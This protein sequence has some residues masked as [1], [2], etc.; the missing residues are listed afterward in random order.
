MSAIS[1]AGGRPAPGPHPHGPASA[2]PLPAGIRDATPP[3]VL[4]TSAGLAW[5]GAVATAVLFVWLGRVVDDGPPAPAGWLAPVLLALTAA[6][7]AGVGA[8]F[9]QW[10]ASAAEQRLRRATVSR[11]FDLGVAGT[12]G[13]S[14][15]LLSLATDAVE[16]IAHYRAAFLG[17]IVGSLTTPLLVLGVMALLVDAVTAGWLV[18]TILLVPLLI[19][20]FQRAVRPIGASYRRT[21]A[22]LTAGFLEAIQALDTLV[23]ARAANRIG[24]DLEA[25]GEEHRRGLMRMLA[26]NQL[27]IFVVDAA[28][29]LT[30]VV[31]ATAIAVVRAA[32]GSISAG[33]A[34]AIVLL[35]VLVTG[36][37]DVIGQFFYIGI[38][39]RAAQRQ[40]AD[41]LGEEPAPRPDATGAGAP[42]PASPPVPAGG[43]ALE[44]VTA[45][46]P[47]GRPV[48]QDLSLSIV[49]GERVA[50]VGPSG[51]GKSTV[52]A[53]IQAHLAPTAG[54]VVVD[55]LD[56]AGDAEAVRSRLTVV[57]QRPF[58]FVGSIAENLRMG[59]PAATDEQLWH[60]L[61]LAGMR[62]EVAAMS[63]GLD[64]PVGEHG[65]L[66]SGGQAQR[67]AIARAALRDAP[68]LLLDEPTSQVDL[69]AEAAIL[70][71]LDRL[72]AGRTVLMIAHRPG[73]ILAADR[74]IALSAPGAAA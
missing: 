3:W 65:A 32:D 10:A 31:A 22:R 19:G 62:S 71:A 53:L 28:F 64:T 37:V 36:P 66:L 69:A 73:A 21:Q 67:L 74:V 46:W 29:S 47:G 48:L 30:V 61:E 52:S 2:G 5:A 39:G 33:S 13:R 1:R 35:S 14:G 25:R 54:R 23:Y 56:T 60:A 40:L 50:L 43:I 8:W 68:I 15:A 6:A 34:I 26:G 63:A 20:G 41:H 24:A 9:S 57:E 51:V 45:A 55:G 27:L 38:G 49:P 17:P 72:A 59:D 58:L 11:I 16:R 4:W 70:A 18:L 7:C 42:A 12:T 44:G